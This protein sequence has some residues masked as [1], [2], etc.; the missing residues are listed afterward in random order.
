MIVTVIKLAHSRQPLDLLGMDE[1]AKREESIEE[2]EQPDDLHGNKE[3]VT[4]QS[5]T[6]EKPFLATQPVDLLSVENDRD[7]LGIWPR[8]SEEPSFVSVPTPLACS[9]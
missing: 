1:V 8:E 3:S 2:T 4:D 7:L 9:D 5:R 6:E